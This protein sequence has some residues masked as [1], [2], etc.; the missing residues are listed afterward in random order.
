[1]QIFPGPIPLWGQEMITLPKLASLRST[2]W[3][4]N[5][6]W[7]RDYGELIALCKV[8]GWEIHIP[9]IAEGRKNGHSA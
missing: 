4:A 5:L 7:L 3:N 8:I 2:K 9:N 1:M 6:I